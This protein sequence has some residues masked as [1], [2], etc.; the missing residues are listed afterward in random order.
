MPNQKKFEFMTEVF[1]EY[2]DEAF[3]WGDYDVAFIKNDI[4]D[5][6]NMWQIYSADGTKLA[7]TD[8]RDFAFV[9]AKQ[10]NL[11]PKSAH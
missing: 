4:Q 8:N 2:E 7:S 5:G 9:V 1:S 11:E 6:K 10:N 3:S